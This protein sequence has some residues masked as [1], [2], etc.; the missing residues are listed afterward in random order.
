MLI[1]TTYWGLNFGVVV[2]KDAISNKFIW[3][4]FIEQKLEDYKLGFKWC[5]EQGYIIK[6]VVSDGFK[7]LA[8][9][10][11]PIAFQIFHMLRAVMAKLTRKPK[12]DAGMELL[13]LSKELCKLS[14]ND[15]INKLSKCQERHKYFLN[16]KTIDE[17]GKWR[18]THT[19]LRSANYTLKRNIAFLFAYES[20]ENLPKTN[21]GL[22]GEFAH[23]KTKLRVH[24][25]LKLEN[26][27]SLFHI[28]LS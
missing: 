18:Y 2:F 15:F 26:K 20:V 28:I 9:T 23:L 4:H 1:D 25:G 19:R 6:A 8:K 3:W 7:G 21:N 24:S 27:M 12:S 5:V 10:L 13:A 16:E 22:E 11:Y 14:S 17:N